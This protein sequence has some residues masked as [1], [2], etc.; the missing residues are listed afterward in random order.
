MLADD[1]YDVWMPNNRG[2]YYSRENLKD[3][4]FSWDDMAFEDF[5][6]VFTYIFKV[7]GQTEFYYVGHSQATSSLLALL[8]EQPKWNQCICAV[9]FLGPVAFVSNE[10]LYSVIAQLVQSAVYVM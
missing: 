5:P 7:T 6:R 10:Q 3:W 4:N 2:S 9:V 1:C 8:S